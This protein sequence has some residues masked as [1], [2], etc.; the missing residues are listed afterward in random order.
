[1][2]LLTEDEDMNPA[3]SGPASVPSLHDLSASSCTSPAPELGGGKD[4]TL[5]A[6]VFSRVPNTAACFAPLHSQSAAA[7]AATLKRRLR[8]KLPR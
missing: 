7:L 2:E 8:C 3:F 4:L 5:S 6:K 1:M